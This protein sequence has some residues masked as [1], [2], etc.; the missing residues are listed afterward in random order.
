MSIELETPDK[1]EYQFHPVTSGSLNF[2][3]KAPNDAHVALTAGPEE[4][5]PMYEV[6]IG[7]WGNT[8]SVIRRDRTKP[9]KA[10][11]ETPDILSGDE[12]R[13][14]WLRW[15]G[16]L[17]EVG[18][19]GEAAPFL[20][21]QDPEPAPVGHYGV[22]TGWGASGAWVLDGG[23]E[24][25]T[26]D[27]LEYQFR[28]VPVGALEVFVRTPSNAHIALTKGPQETEPMY[29]IILGGWENSASVI[30][31]NRE[32]P[33]KVRE[34]T[35]GLLGSD[36]FR[37]FEV[38]WEHGLVSVRAGAGGGAPLIQWRDPAHIGVTHFGVRTAWGAS[39]RW[40]LRTFDPRSNLPQ[41][42]APGFSVPSA[43]PAGSTPTWV[44][45]R[46][47]E[48]PPEAVPGGFDGEQLYVG[49]AQH[50]GAL[51]PGK[52]VP[53]HG[54]CYVAWGG[55]EHGKEEYQ[56]LCGCDVTWVPTAGGEIPSNA[57][58]SGE[59]EDGE[60]LFTGRAQHEGTVTVGKV[61]ASHN[62]CYIPYGGQE[63]GYPDYEVLVPK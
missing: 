52:V 12:F 45:A 1:L 33:D 14:F 21:W 37:R 19:E 20:S 28:P 39:G 47:G 53:S 42:G 43:P 3:I 34:D 50:E 27:K 18:K 46:A 2:K 59:T 32:K 8:K 30:R 4:A 61:Q 49:R 9:D 40:R 35:P 44:D 11:A 54:V 36:D 24:V 38:R 22:C 60:P 63:L 16:G 10:E 15:N 17:I 7:G 51:I 58:P 25:Q 41:A 56:V 31:Y 5:D 29:E 55:A 26:A 6:F 13:G 48:V 23:H 57:L 62:V